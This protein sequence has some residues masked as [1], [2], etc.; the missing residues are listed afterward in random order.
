MFKE[1]LFD[2][3]QSL[4]LLEQR[5][6]VMHYEYFTKSFVAAKKKEIAAFKIVIAYYEFL[7]KIE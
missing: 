2:L 1:I 5:F 7:A 6:A 3:V 4:E